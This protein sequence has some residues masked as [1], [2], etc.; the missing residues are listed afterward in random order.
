MGKQVQVKDGITRVWL[1]PGGV[2]DEGDIVVLRD[3]EYDALTVYVQEHLT[4]LDAEV[5]D[6]DR[7]A[8]DPGAG[9]GLTL[10][11]DIYYFEINNG[12]SVPIGNTPVVWDTSYGE[13]DGYTDY[14]G[15][16]GQLELPVGAYAV[17][18]E[19]DVSSPATDR[20]IWSQ[21]AGTRSSVSAGQVFI[22][23]ASNG[24]WVAG[25]GV[26][27]VPSQGEGIFQQVTI[28]HH[29]VDPEEVDPGALNIT[30]ASLTLRK[31]Y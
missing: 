9:S 19:L 11:G 24:G 23:A 28:G 17:D 30:F 26:L 22:S 15:P 14:A 6:P 8:P 1:Y 13:G 16:L 4:V 29:S 31:I 25:S 20:K 5:D 18:W 7:S 2:F 3:D 10:D 21:V 12:F 27:V